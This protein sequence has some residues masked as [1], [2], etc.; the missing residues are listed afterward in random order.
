[1]RLGRTLLTLALGAALPALASSPPAPAPALKGIEVGDLDRKVDP[2]TDFYAFANGAWRQQNPIPP[3]MVRWSR[4]W[5]A[6]ESA[7]ERL[8]EILDEVSQRRDWKPGSVEQLIGD[9]YGACMDEAAVEARGVQPVEPLLQQIAALKDG[10]GVQGMIATLH[11]MS[12]PVPFGL[13]AQSAY[14]EPT[15]VIVHLFASGLGLPDRDYYVK[16]EPRFVEAREKYRAHVARL[17]QLAGRSEAEAKQ[18]GEDVLAMETELA[19]ASLDNVAL[20]DPANTDHMMKFAAL[21]KLAPAFDWA[22][23]YRR[24]GVQRADLNVMEPKFLQELDRQLK[25]TPLPRWKTYLTWHVLRAAAPQLTRAFVQEDF[26]F[27]QQYLGGAK[28]LKPRWK[29][30]VESTD[31]LLGEALGKKYVERYFPPA[32]KARMQVMVKD[33]L[34]S[35]GDTIQGLDWMGPQTKKQALEKLATFNPKIGYPDKWKDYSS[36]KVDRA[37]HWENVVAGRKF[38]MRDA[39]STVNRPVDRGRWDITPPTSDA[40][41]NPSL[42]EI[43][44]P[45]GILQ[46]PAFSMEANDAVNYGAIGVVIGHEISHGFDDQGAKFDAQ[47]R[48]RDWWQPADLK[49]FSERGACVVQ[50]FDKYP[51]EGGVFHNGKLVLGESI[52]DLAGAKIAYGALQRAM[53]RTPVP[54]VDGFTPEQQFFIAWGQFRGDAVRPETQ[55]LMVQ[56][57][58]HPIGKYRVVGPLSNLREF[59]QAF[60]CKDGAPMVRPAAQRCEVW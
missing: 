35:M 56:G 46:P 1:M 9:H 47:G 40:Y 27:D 51:V 6:G 58:P 17:F 55:R 11:Q 14:A 25:E 45:A 10:A 23:Y 54:T 57:D 8:K 38:A 19:R 12:L 33:L 42:N 18:A 20:R 44:F 50:Q 22:G 13:A 7:K 16:T 29:R 53:K 32:A 36:V 21:Q 28:E 39:L 60:Q 34:A 31:R 41:Y 59:Q 26:A 2:C 24:L 30:C 37:H 3:S 52:G 43:V 48:L 4:R 49:H 5:Q 15:R